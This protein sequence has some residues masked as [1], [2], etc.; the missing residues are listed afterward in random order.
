[1]CNQLRTRIL[2]CKLSQ[3]KFQAQLLWRCR[4]MDS[5]T[6]MTLLFTL[7]I[8]QTRTSSIKASLLRTS[9]QTVPR[10]LDTPIS[11]W[12]VCFST[13]SRTTMA[14]PR[15]LTTSADTEIKVVKLSSK[16]ETWPKF[17]TL[18]ISAQH[19]QPTTLVKSSLKSNK[20]TLTGRMLAETLCLR[21]VLELQLLIHNL[22]WPRT[23]MV[24][25]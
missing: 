25:S 24:P 16:K 1:M 8:H 12:P 22:V 15:I 18:N 9:C 6:L 17:P 14:Q 7:E 20:T 21:E 4:V 19:H 2:L 3:F 10:P 11:T 23:L 5:N 13:S